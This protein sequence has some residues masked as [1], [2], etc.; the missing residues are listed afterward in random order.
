M[1]IVKISGSF[2][3]DGQKCPTGQTYDNNLEA[4]INNKC[5]NNS[6][7]CNNEGGLK[8]GI[9]NDKKYPECDCVCPDGKNNKLDKHVCSTTCGNTGSSCDVNT[10][11]GYF[12]VTEDTFNPELS[13][14]NPSTNNSCKNKYNGSTLFCSDP[15]ECSGS[16]NEDN[17]EYCIYN[18]SSTPE[19]ECKNNDYMSCSLAPNSNNP[20][21]CGT[22]IPIFPGS[23]NKIGY[24]SNQYKTGTNLKI[25]NIC[26][27]DKK[28]ISINSNGNHICC[29]TI[30][31]PVDY[32]R[33]G[34]NDAGCCLNDNLCNKNC[35]STSTKGKVCTKKGGF[36]DKD[37][38]Y[39]GSGCKGDK[40]NCDNCC[41][42][43]AINN[44]CGLLSKFKSDVPSNVPVT[45]TN[46]KQ[47]GQK[48]IDKLYNND[49]KVKNTDSSYVRAYCDTNLTDKEKKDSHISK[50]GEGL[51]K[52]ICGL[53]DQ[54]KYTVL[55]DKVEEGNYSKNNSHCYSQGNCDWNVPKFP[56][57]TIESGT[58]SS[59]PKIICTNNKIQ[60]W[61][62]VAG[63]ET[64]NNY[65]AN[66]T[67]NSGKNSSLCTKLDCEQK[68]SGIGDGSEAALPDITLDEK[69]GQ[70]T[71][72]FNCINL[73]ETGNKIEN[74]TDFFSN[75]KSKKK[76]YKPGIKWSSGK[77][78][79]K[80]GVAAKWN[81][82]GYFDTSKGSNKCVSYAGSNPTQNAKDCKFLDSG[83][84]CE[85]GSY[86]G[87]S[88][89][90]TN[91]TNPISSKDLCPGSET[92]TNFYPPYIS[93]SQP[94]GSYT[95]AMYECDKVH[96]RK[97]GF[98][99]DSCCSNGLVGYLNGNYCQCLGNFFYQNGTMNCNVP[100]RTSLH[101]S[102][103]EKVN[104]SYY[105]L[106]TGGGKNIDI[107]GKLYTGW[108]P[109][110]T[111][112]PAGTNK[113]FL[114]IL[115]A[116]VPQ[117]NGQLIKKYLNLDA[118]KY[119]NSSNPN[120][121]STGKLI[122]QNLDST[123]PLRFF[124]GALQFSQWCGPGKTIDYEQQNSNLN[125][126]LGFIPPQGSGFQYGKILNGD[127][128]VKKEDQ[129]LGIASLNQIVAN[130]QLK[131]IIPIPVLYNGQPQVDKQDN[132]RYKAY[133]YLFAVHYNVSNSASSSTS[134]TDTGESYY[135]QINT[136]TNE[137][138][139]KN[140]TAFAEHNI[141]DVVGKIPDD[142]KPTQFII[143]LFDDISPDSS[144]PNNPH[145]WTIEKIINKSSIKDILDAYNQ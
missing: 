64:S 57:E 98:G 60:Y 126:S 26:C 21:N 6:D 81:N 95:K 45:C 27:E 4:C 28:K 119:T 123:V 82:K 120:N 12:N 94:Y 124:Y 34:F 24:C 49:G 36:C 5:S 18:S 65:K 110:P 47:C 53:E 100:Y 71:A 11:C 109:P 103:Y 46:D 30:G 133:V 140:H 72:T 22:C 44:T 92:V 78:P 73:N 83:I 143:E 59:E 16:L 67:I 106:N 51:C 40:K 25:G 54:T 66:V 115:S 39:G 138:E 97:N 87:Y 132:N 113:K 99:Y 35:L 58:Y 122:M 134:Y 141:Q 31:I 136:A 70:C 52:I 130:N 104:R 42:T 96:G 41:F 80:T 84:F 61:K 62:P 108:G 121:A 117:Q 48:E 69:S 20:S 101:K 131:S 1:G 56:T 105:W 139:F 68:F 118:N 13:C 10:E 93:C 107:L 144:S 127:Q 14:V 74:F 9:L 102:N 88:C 90:N 128:T 3:P 142:K 29:S 38:A 19:D 111:P 2:K 8:N 114:L 37:N 135:A 91:I 15:Y 33:G 17:N 7:Y 32:S 23:E 112:P 137:I 75:I 129:S 79:D 77:Y 50:P 86:D 76:S 116:Y 145:G 85:N 43:K 89:S 125:V 55:D 63:Q